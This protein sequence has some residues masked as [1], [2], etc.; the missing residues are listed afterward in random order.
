MGEGRRGVAT[1]ILFKKLENI[2]PLHSQM[3][4]EVT[5]GT[6]LMGNL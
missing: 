1:C 3:F 4:D 5:A 6:C 2:W